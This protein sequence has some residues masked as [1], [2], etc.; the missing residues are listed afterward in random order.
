[1][2]AATPRHSLIALIFKHCFNRSSIPHHIHTERRLTLLAS[3]EPLE[4]RR[5][6]FLFLDKG[7]EIVEIFAPLPT[8]LPSY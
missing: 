3:C 5:W 6:F 8:E 4:T 1:M 7:H 2:H